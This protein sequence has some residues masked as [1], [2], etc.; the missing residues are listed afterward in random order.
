MSELD[1]RATTWAES[2]PE[3]LREGALRLFDFLKETDR[4]D[5][6]FARGV[7]V[8]ETGGFVVPLCE[9]HRHDPELEAECTEWLGRRN[10]ILFLVL[11]SVG[12]RIGAVGIALGEEGDART[13]VLPAPG[14]DG[15]SS[16]AG[17]LALLRWIEG[18]VR[19]RA[20]VA[21]TDTAEAAL[22][23]ALGFRDFNGSLL[24]EPER[25]DPSA[26]MIL[27]AGPA[28]SP[29]ETS[30]ALDATRSGWNDRWSGYLD[31]FERSFADFLG[32]KHA[33][34]TSSC[35]GA[36]HLALAALGIGPGDEVVVPDITWVATANAVSYVGAT[37]VFADV[38][39][40]SW[41]LDADCFERSITDKTRAVVP[42]HLYGHPA[43]MT[44]I[45]EIAA[46][47]GIQV[48]EDAA[49][50][51][52]AQWQGQKTGT[53]GAFAAFSFQGAKLVVS[54]E[55]GIVV[56]DDDDLYAELRL[57]WDQGRTPG[58]FWIGH[59]GLK[60]K[61]A[62]VQAAVALGQLERVE[63][64]VVAKRSIFERYAEALAD[65]PGVSL[66]H[67]VAG[68][69]SIYWMTSLLLDE[70]APIGRD[71]LAAALKERNV[72]TR[73]VFPTIS[74][75]P[76]WKQSPAARNPVAARIGDNA[77]NLPSGVLLR[78]EQVD[79]VARCVREILAG[80]Q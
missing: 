80:A 41:C 69:R 23:H 1:T 60:Y 78:P 29:R 66:N 22:L 48:V 9:L 40:D 10:R 68:A 16:S 79:Y 56:T 5:A 30:Y 42:V 73:P 64:L 43:R 55:G 15:T 24:F 35:T 61:M 17:I 67:E 25:P 14:R 28:I 33:L 62:N 38:E 34:A 46:S 52:G 63:E 26:A 19:P 2:D 21:S 59:S 18:F 74:R 4:L 7:S 57:I 76:I 54:G 58:T 20:I 50:A 47:H 70:T 13:A 36:L 39:A 12:R 32:V 11:D 75:Y 49:P 53:F 45:L 71:R 8:E 37:P 72:D 6:L 51:I 44:R 31:R 27:T 3:V 65:T 77:L